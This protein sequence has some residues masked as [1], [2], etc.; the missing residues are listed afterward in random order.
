MQAYFYKL[1]RR[2]VDGALIIAVSQMEL[3]VHRRVIPDIRPSKAKWRY[4]RSCNSWNNEYFS[5]SAIQYE[6]PVQYINL[7]RLHSSPFTRN[8]FKKTI[9][10]LLETFRIT[11]IKNKRKNL[12]RFL[13]SFCFLKN[14]ICACRCIVSEGSISRDIQ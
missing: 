6:N 4:F 13:S 14:F 1:K 2:V 12:V 9:R 10:E 8:N 11:N 3:W 7:S 5:T